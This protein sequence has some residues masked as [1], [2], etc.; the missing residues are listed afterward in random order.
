M[1]RLKLISA[2]YEYRSKHNEEFVL[3]FEYKNG[4]FSEPY[5]HS[6]NAPCTI[7]WYWSAG[8]DDIIREDELAFELEQFDEWVK[9]N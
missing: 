3:L 7:K 1:G 5:V 8:Y 6:P 4:V 9:N 2:A